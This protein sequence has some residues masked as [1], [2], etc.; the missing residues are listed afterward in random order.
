[1]E[2][3]KLITKDSDGKVLDTREIDSPQS[4]PEALK[5]FGSKRALVEAAMRQHKVETRAAIKQALK[6]TSGTV[7]ASSFDESA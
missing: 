6:G 1:M 3:I 7:R 2:K 5:V 4:L